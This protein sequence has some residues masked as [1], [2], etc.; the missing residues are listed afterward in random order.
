MLHTISNLYEFTRKFY[1]VIQL[2]LT[3]SMLLQFLIIVLVIVA[4]LS[5][6]ILTPALVKMST[7]FAVSSEITK[8]VL[9]SNLLGLSISG[10]FYGPIS[11]HYGRRPVILIGLIIFCISSILCYFT[12]TIDLLILFRFFQ[13]IGAGV[14]VVIGYASIKDV[15]D[16]VRCAQVIS[17][18]SMCVA[19]S[20]TFGPILGSLIMAYYHWTTVFVI[21][22]FAA[23]I[24]FVIFLFFFRETLD[25]KTASHINIKEIFLS[26]VYVLTNRRFFGFSIITMC[27][28]AWVWNYIGTTP[29]LFIHSMHVSVRDYG[30]L[31][32]FNVAMYVIGTVI[33][34]IFVV[35]YGIK[36]MLWIG[37]PLPIISDTIVLISHNFISLNPW[38]MEVIWIPMDIG[39]ALILGNAITSALQETEEYRGT[40]NAVINCLNMTCGGIGVMVFG[41]FYNGT[42][43]PPTITTITCSVIALL[44]YSCLSKRSPLNKAA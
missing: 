8:I 32:A 21:L 23:V 34:Q 28:Y 1:P 43:V 15:Y 12:N 6:D 5:T 11:D 27:T 3:Q 41:Y 26:Y 25:K 10:L 2:F 44:V 39:L 22:I 33:N 9:S 42:V 24:V 4:E 40:G 19:L 20:P 29:F 16:D 18:V 37:L 17:R 35:K 7:F 13:G 36:R 14:A 38:L 31:S 30:Y